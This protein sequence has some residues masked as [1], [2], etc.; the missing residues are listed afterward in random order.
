MANSITAFE[1]G[2]IV[3]LLHED[4]SFIFFAEMGLQVIKS[5]DLDFIEQKIIGK[6]DSIILFI[7]LAS[8]ILLLIKF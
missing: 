8:H 1:V 7:H 6:Y 2:T 5:K 4:G 3:D